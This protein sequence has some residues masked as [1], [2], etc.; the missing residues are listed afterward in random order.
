MLETGCCSTGNQYEIGE[1]GGE[2]GRNTHSQS[3]TAGS[4][5]REE[6]RN[7]TVGR[8]I[9]ALQP[10]AQESRSSCILSPVGEA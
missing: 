7:S 10:V 2:G 8:F 3:L 4:L 6:K 9:F 1:R 5:K